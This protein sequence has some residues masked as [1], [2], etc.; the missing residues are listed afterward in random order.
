MD[1]TLP[2]DLI[3]VGTAFTAYIMDGA[4]YQMISLSSAVTKATVTEPSGQAATQA[5]GLVSFGVDP[6]DATQITQGAGVY[7]APFC[8]PAAKLGTNI[9]SNCG[10]STDLATATVVSAATKILQ[11]TNAIEI[12]W[13]L[14]YDVPNDRTWADVV[15]KTQQKASADTVLKK[16]T[17]DPLVIH[18]ASVMAK[19]WGTG[20]CFYM[21][22]IATAPGDHL[23][24]C[25]DTGKLAKSSNLQL[26]FQFHINEAGKDYTKGVHATPANNIVALVALTLTCELKIGTWSAA[27]ASAKNWY[28][29][30][31]TTQIDGNTQTSAF[32]T[33]SSFIVVKATFSSLGVKAVSGDKYKLSNQNDEAAMWLFLTDAD[34][35]VREDDIRQFPFSTKLT[36]KELYFK[37]YGSGLKTAAKATF[38]LPAAA[39]FVANA[40][41]NKF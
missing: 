6:N 30:M 19:G 4:M 24:Q 8:L 13:A 23:F 25:R 40:S 14:P 26:A 17:H 37:G 10:I 16:W 31:F 35:L 34:K 2:T 15:C 1:V 9:E 39:K 33:W 41:L 36:D 20:N 29:S 22:A 32:G 11:V 3:G 27:T 18:Q 38:L 28:Q 7:S 12:N 5:T 21:G